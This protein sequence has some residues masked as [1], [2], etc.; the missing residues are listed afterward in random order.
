[1]PLWRA[2][3][4]SWRSLNCAVERRG[5]LGKCETGPGE[6]T[7]CRFSDNRPRVLFHEPAVA[8]DQ[9]LSGQRIGLCPGEIEYSV[10][11]EEHTSELQSLMRISYAVFCLKKTNNTHSKKSR[12]HIYPTTTCITSKHH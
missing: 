7:R 8:D 9:R 5:M 10:R 4:G 12:Q 2:G 11:S 1:M 3:S 6:K